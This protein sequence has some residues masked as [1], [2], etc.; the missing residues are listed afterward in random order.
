VTT[1][2]SKNYEPLTHPPSAYPNSSDGFLR[3]VENLYRRGKENADRN[4][5]I[6][7]TTITTAAVDFISSIDDDLF[8]DIK[9]QFASFE[10]WWLSSNGALRQIKNNPIFESPSSTNIISSSSTH[11]S[12]PSWTATSPSQILKKVGV[13]S[14]REPLS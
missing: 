7:Q 5:S 13:R 3:Y 4:R 8:A 11:Q 6:S 12:I 2:Y 1:G 14:A 9:E 10:K